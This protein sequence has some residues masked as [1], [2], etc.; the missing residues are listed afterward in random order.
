MSLTRAEDA[1]ARVTFWTA[2]VERLGADLRSALA[3]LSS[4]ESK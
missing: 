2:E 1:R 4:E 3:E